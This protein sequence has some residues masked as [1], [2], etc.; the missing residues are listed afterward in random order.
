M[1]FKV[2]FLFLLFFLLMN[3]S[4]AALLE[5]KWSYPTGTVNKIFLEDLDGDGSPEIIAWV[6]DT[7]LA[8]NLQGS[9]LWSFEKDDL[10][11]VTISDLNSDGKKEIILSSGRRMAGIERSFL[12]ILNYQGKLILKYPSSKVALTLLLK[13]IKALLP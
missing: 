13:D 2:I 7:L 6:S 5:E 3:L 1:N 11:S 9:L 10:L 4:S 8:L 12:W